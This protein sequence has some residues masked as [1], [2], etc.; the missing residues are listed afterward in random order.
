[1]H[2]LSAVN[3]AYV[4]PNN[5]YENDCY[6]LI[7]SSYEIPRLMMGYEDCGITGHEYRD[8]PSKTGV[9]RTDQMF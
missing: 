2:R 4:V 5:T 8:Y 3:P 7:T 6:D 1:M 9:T